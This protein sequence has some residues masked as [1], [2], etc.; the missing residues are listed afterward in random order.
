[1]FRDNV[2]GIGLRLPAQ[3]HPLSQRLGVAS[4][5]DNLSEIICRRKKHLS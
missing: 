5:S 1:M 2:T 3:R 4:N